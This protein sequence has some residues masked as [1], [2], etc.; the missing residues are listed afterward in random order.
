MKKVISLIKASMSEG[1]NIFKVKQN[2]K[3]SDIRKKIFP[4]FLFLIVMYGIGTYAYLIAKPLSKIGLTHIMLSMM[5]MFVSMY[6]IIEGFYKSQGMLFECKDNDLILSMPIEKRT[7]FFVRMFKFYLFQLMYDS[8]FILPAFIIY[9][10]FENPNINFYLMSL[11]MLILLPLLPLII[12]SVIGYIIKIISLNF[13]KSKNVQTIISMLLLVGVFYF[14]FNIE[15]L[16]SNIVSNANVINSIITKIYYPI[17]LYILLINK[18]NLIC[19]IKLILVNIPPFVIFIY[20]GSLYYFK[21]IFKSKKVSSNKNSKKLSFKRK[22]AVLSLTK[23][24][25]KTYFSIPV[26]IINTLFGMV[27]MVILTILLCTNVNGFISILQ[28]SSDIIITPYLINKYAP[29]FFLE[30]ILFT[31]FM[32]Q[33]TCSSISLEGKTFNILKSYPVSEKKIFISKIL[34]NMVLTTPIILM[35]DLIFL[36]NFNVKSI[37]IVY[38]ILFSFLAP[39]FSSLYGLVINLKYPKLKWNNETEVIKQSTSTMICTFTGM[40]LFFGSVFIVI[41]FI[42]NINFVILIEL[43]VLLIINLIL[44]FTLLKNGTSEFRKLSY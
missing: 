9:A 20:L 44:W 35:C 12:A 21:I 15:N 10:Y 34:F 14:S 16:V 18:F 43:F 19:L 3:T 4:I 13:K 17:N 30:M 39:L 29:I 26:Y 36:I 42:K 38:I 28:S 25:L 22:N 6:T 27:L 41:T 5:I 40:G 8:L 31:G 11:I 32:T 23:K 37:Y 24:E 7:V 33:I 2:N 1:M